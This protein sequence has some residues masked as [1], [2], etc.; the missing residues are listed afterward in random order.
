VSVRRRWHAFHGWCLSNGVKPFTLSIVEFLD[1]VHYFILT[2]IM[3]EDEDE[4]EAPAPVE[5]G[6][7]PPPAWMGWKDTRS[8][9]DAL[10]AAWE[11]RNK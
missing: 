11:A 8:S 3:P 1:L 5:E 9:H 2:G 7:E 6:K 4:I 10:V